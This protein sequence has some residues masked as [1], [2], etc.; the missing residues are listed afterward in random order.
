MGMR[1]VNRTERY[2]G[3]SIKLHGRV[4]RAGGSRR[5]GWLKGI[6]CVFTVR[7]NGNRVTVLV[8][9]P[10][11]VRTG[12]GSNVKR[13]SN[14][15]PVVWRRVV[16]HIGGRV[17]RRVDVLTLCRLWPAL[18]GWWQ[19]L[20]ALG[21]SRRAQTSRWRRGS[22]ARGVWV[23]AGSITTGA[24]SDGRRCDRAAMKTFWAGIGGRQVCRVL[25]GGQ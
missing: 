3:R 25:H 19:R 5:Q 7:G 12:V 11:R 13:R 4:S 23:P 16:V 21:R 20:H 9:V 1:C 6:K 2:R 18:A 22:E 10:D 17:I 14:R 8:R 15:L 24:R